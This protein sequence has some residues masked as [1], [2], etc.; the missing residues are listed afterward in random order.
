MEGCKKMKRNETILEN[1]PLLEIVQ[2]C[3]NLLDK[4]SRMAPFLHD[5]VQL[6]DNK[7]RWIAIEGDN[8]KW[9]TAKKSK[10]CDRAVTVT[11][12]DFF[13]LLPNW[14][15]I[16]KWEKIWTMFG[17]GLEKKHFHK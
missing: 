11:S 15:R 6:F 3:K 1:L 5:S 13:L 17:Y 4:L 8:K 2:K 9:T 14:P 7:V 16:E 12:F 10:K